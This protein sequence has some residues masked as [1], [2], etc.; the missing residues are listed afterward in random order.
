VGDIT[1]YRSDDADLLSVVVLDRLTDIVV[2][3]EDTC[4]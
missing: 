4:Y 3:E 1:V 2:R